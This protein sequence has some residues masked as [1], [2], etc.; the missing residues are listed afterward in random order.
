MRLPFGP[1][2]PDLPSIVNQQGLV[3][4]K[5]ML[6]QA[7]GY[8]P[9]RGLAALSGATVLSAR[10]RGSVSGIDPAGSGYLYAGEETKLQVQRDAGMTD[11]SQ[12]GGYA[13]GA[14]DRW[15]LAKFGNRIFAATIA[16]NMQTHVIGSPDLFA[17]VPPF[18]PRA[19]HIATIGNFLIAGNLY[20]A[21]DGPM[22]DAIRWPAIDNPLNWPAFGSDG[23]VSVQADR[24][25]LEGN[26][27]AVQDIV[28]G[29]EIAAV[30]QERAIHRLD[31]R[32][33]PFVFEK[34]RMEEGNG[35]LIPY[36]AVAFERMV[37]YIA[38]DGFRLFD[39]IGSKAIG[40][41]RVSQTFLADLDTQY[42][43]RVETGKDPDRTVIWVIY[44]GSGNTGGRPNKVIW[45]D[46]VLDRFSHGEL[47]L[48]GLI[49][50][51]T[52]SAL[53]IDAPAS[54]GDPDDVDDPSG[55]DSFDDRQSSFGSSRMGAFDSTFLA[56]DFSGSF[57]EGLIETGDI[58]GA[59]G[60]WYWIDGIRPLVDSRK[61]EVAV[62]ERALR[63]D[64]VVFGPY[65]PIDT[66]GEVSLRSDAR[67]HRIRVKLPAGWTDAVGLDIDGSISGGR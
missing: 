26:G 1:Y 16:H 62:A 65:M 4:A 23:A 67:Y 17:D 41:D 42:M 54:A 44:P 14:T 56:S 3:Q 11:I 10:P 25:P 58:E 7:G 2:M 29:A 50:N 38:E 22:P 6:P 13:L 52:T 21:E 55:E 33:G 32:G 40:K 63:D 9:V 47:E 12:T 59:P 27:G 15:S 18:A 34:N 20:D 53:S 51:A 36:S 19:R 31:Y 24:Q 64:D 39:Y 43:D 66:D 5:N 46:Y 35:M 37:F 57:L 48:E 8:D 61:V 60:R 28:S 45:Y 30:F 49:V